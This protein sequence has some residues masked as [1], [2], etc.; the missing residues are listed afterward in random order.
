[1][2]NCIALCPLEWSLKSNNE[3]FPVAQKLH[4]HEFKHFNFSP[5]F[6]LASQQHGKNHTWMPLRSGGRVHKSNPSECFLSAVFVKVECYS[7]WKYIF[8]FVYRMHWGLLS[9]TNK[10]ENKEWW[11]GKDIYN[12]S[13]TFW[14]LKV[15]KYWDGQVI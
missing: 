6:C 2:F 12:N 14:L 7:V 4:G 9:E 5:T 1:M 11:V 13:P 8:K 3:I 10:G 15:G